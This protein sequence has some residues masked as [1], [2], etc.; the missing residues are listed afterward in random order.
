MNQ[1]REDLGYCMGYDGCLYAAGG[2]NNN[3]S[4]LNSCERFNWSKFVWESI[5]GMKNPRRAFTLIPV[6]HGI[7]AIGGHSSQKVLS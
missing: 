7:F 5:A 6:P 2:V 3:K 4:Y 1:Y